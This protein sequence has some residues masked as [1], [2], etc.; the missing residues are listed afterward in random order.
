MASEIFAEGG[1]DVA[2]TL[3]PGANGVLQVFIDGE[4]AFDK[5]AE[6][7]ETPTLPRVKEI[8][9]MVRQKLTAPVAAD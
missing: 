4:T 5:K 1:K 6:G 9:A 7:N 8:R 3:T 2:I